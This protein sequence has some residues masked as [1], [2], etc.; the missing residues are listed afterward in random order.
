MSGDIGFEQGKQAT[1][2][3]VELYTGQPVKDDGKEGR[4]RGD[5]EW[6]FRDRIIAERIDTQHCSAETGWDTY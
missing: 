1:D 4:R 2:R 3:Y 5:H 6:N